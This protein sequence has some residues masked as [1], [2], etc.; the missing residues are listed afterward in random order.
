MKKKLVVASI[1]A[2]FLAAIAGNVTAGNVPSADSDETR[3]IVEDILKK[4]QKGQLPAELKEKN[5]HHLLAVE[6]KDTPAQE[7]H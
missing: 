3:T 5:E 6:Q 4:Q 2:L 1:G 7:K